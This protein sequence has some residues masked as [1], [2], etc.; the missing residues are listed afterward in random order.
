[1]GK[2]YS[3]NDQEIGS[4]ENGT[5]KDTRGNIL[6]YYNESN[7]EIYRLGSVA[8]NYFAAYEYDK[9]YR[10][11]GFA[12]SEVGK[13]ISERDWNG[14]DGKIVDNSGNTIAFYRGENCIG[15]GA[16]A[17]TLVF[18]LY[19]SGTST[20]VGSQSSGSD[21]GGCFSAI[22]HILLGIIVFIPMCIWCVLPL[23]MICIITLAAILDGINI[24]HEELMVQIMGFLIVISLIVGSVNAIRIIKNSRQFKL[25]KKQVRLSRLINNSGVIVFYLFS[26]VINASTSYAPIS[27]G[28]PLG[29]A[30]TPAFG[31]FLEI[32]A[33]AAMCLSPILT[34]IYLRKC[35]TK[36][37]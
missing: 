35:K 27:S 36:K 6:A 24:S 12:Q 26:A 8:N 1:M 4:Y 15:L 16:A 23:C 3:M 21:S 29:D 25:E 7:G 32:I 10:K 28:R 20:A 31:P 37:P 34:I 30:D 14:H 33:L 19:D 11:N 13:V 5:V 2:I 9:I 17:A 18:F 22:V